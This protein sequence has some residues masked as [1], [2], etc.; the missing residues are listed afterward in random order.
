MRDGEGWQ[1]RD[2]E[3]WQL[4]DCE[5]LRIQENQKMRCTEVHLIR[6]PPE[7]ILELVLENGPEN[8]FFHFFQPICFWKA[9][10]KQEMNL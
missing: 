5:G 3:G 9:E 7:A 4:R 6:E 1:L 8:Q 2:G 10:T